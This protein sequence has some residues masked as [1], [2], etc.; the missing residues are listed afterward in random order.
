M[1]ALVADFTDPGDI[2]LDP[3]CGSGTTGVAAIRLGRRFVGIERD[4]TYAQLARDRI[5]AE[6]SGSTLSA[7][8][9]GQVA[10]FG[11]P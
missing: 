11:V 3:F 9:A 1:E 2:I 7:Q 5:S 6:V 4:P 10:L 8:R